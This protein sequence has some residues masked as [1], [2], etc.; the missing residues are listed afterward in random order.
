MTVLGPASPGQLQ[1]TVLHTVACS[2]AGTLQAC[3]DAIR[4]VQLAA[5]DAVG[6]IC[7]MWLLRSQEQSIS[8]F[9]HATMEQSTGE[10]EGEQ[11]SAS[12]DIGRNSMDAVSLSMRRV[13]DV[14]LGAGA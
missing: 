14:W 4:P 8:A 12:A 2:I 1:C 10:Q 6:V 3:T 7:W 9:V 11:A 5:G 13:V